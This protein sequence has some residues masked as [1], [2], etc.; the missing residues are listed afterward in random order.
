MESNK[1]VT[2][3]SSN[4]ISNVVEGTQ[5]ST[6][7]KS[8]VDD[9]KDLTSK[10]YYFDSYAHFGIHEEMLKDSVRTQTYRRSMIHNE[11]LFKDK[12]VLDIGCGT[13]I[14]SMFAAQAGAK[15][16]IGIDYS[17]IIDQAKIIVKENKMDDRVTLIR[18]KVE[19]IEKLPFDIE[20]VDIIVSEWMGYCL[21]YESML[22]TI[23]FARDKWLKDDGALFP[24]RAS[25]FITAI[26]DR[27]YRDEKINW[28]KNVYGYN[29]SAIRTVALTEPLVDIVEAQSVVTDTSL[30]KTI[31]LYKVK[32]EDLT[33]ENNFELTARRNDYVHAFVT[34]FTVEFSKCHTKTGF[35]TSPFSK[36]TH[37]KQTV[38]YINNSLTIKQKQKIKG[39][40]AMG[41]N[42]KNFRDLDIK[43]EYEFDSD[44]QSCREAL[45]YY[46]R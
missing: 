6:N 25:L 21:L 29:M 43:I 15:R 2:Q 22:N 35:S 18:G 3:S 31:D 41:P 8:E 36:Y 39:R 45:Q 17:S 33:F 32:A 42:E 27:N 10:D 1:E 34:F 5:S 14:L 30:I 40:V 23:I 16:V 37:W 20:K 26:E 24:D 19:D 46:M 38:F 9:K 4:D 7:G 28:W 44:I 13:G 12:I 11:H